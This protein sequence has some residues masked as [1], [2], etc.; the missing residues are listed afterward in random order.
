MIRLQNIYKSFKGIEVLEDISLDI[1]TGECVVLSGVSGSGKSTLL[2]IIGSFMK[3]TSGDV[4]VNN[5]DILNLNDF[6]LSEFRKD[7]LGFITQSFHLFETLNVRENILPALLLSQLSQ[8]EIYSKI[9]E[10]TKL[11]DMEHKLDTQ[12]ALLSGGEKQRCIIARTLVNNP[13]IILCDE[14]TANLDKENT[15]VFI[16]I[17]HALKKQGKTIV[18]ATHDPLIKELDFV[19]KIIYMKDGRIE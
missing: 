3:P 19:D 16:E 2:S 6:R 8:E 15:L 1:S 9:S 18:I 7:I 17:I 5:T 11:V 12:V 13:K 14:P 10:L 4:S